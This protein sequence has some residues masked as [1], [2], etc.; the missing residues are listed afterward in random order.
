MGLAAA[1]AH[2]GEASL[3][4]KVGLAFRIMAKLVIISRQ[5]SFAFSIMRRCNW[6]DSP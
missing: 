5:H 1:K 2:S 3:S 4:S 6:P